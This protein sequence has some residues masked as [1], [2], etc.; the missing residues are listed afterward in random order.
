MHRINQR[1]EFGNEVARF[2]FENNLPLTVLAQECGV[3]Y[4]SLRA[5]MYG[6]APGPALI[7]KVQ[8]FMSIRSYASEPTGS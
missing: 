8:D 1:T 6:R 2:S 5:V 7:Q 3:S 4:E